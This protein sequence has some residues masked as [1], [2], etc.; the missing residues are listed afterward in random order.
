MIKGSGLFIT[1]ASKE[2]L[3]NYIVNK[4]EKGLTAKQLTVAKI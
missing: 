3:L 1:S 2:N 4:S